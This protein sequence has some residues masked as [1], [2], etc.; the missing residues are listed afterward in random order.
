MALIGYSHGG[1][2]AGFVEGRTDRFKALAAGA[3]V[4][5]QFSENGTEDPSFYDRW[6]YGKP[7]GHFGGVPVTLITYPRETH[8]TLGRAFAAE[9]TREPWHGVDLRRRMIAFIKAA[10]DGVKAP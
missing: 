3:P 1:E 6:D 4:I 10:F 2:M 9:P 8:A 5:D 7:W